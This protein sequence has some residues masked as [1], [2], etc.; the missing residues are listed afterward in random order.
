M[1]LMTDTCAL[2]TGT[3]ASPRSETIAASL[4]RPSDLHKI[5]LVFP[6]RPSAP[7]HQRNHWT[8][9][10]RSNTLSTGT[11]GID[12]REYGDSEN[13]TNLPPKP[14]RRGH[15][16]QPSPACKAYC[17]SLNLNDITRTYLWRKSSDRIP[18][19]TCPPF[20]DT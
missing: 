3:I 19:V 20:A 15:S 16:Y 7:K 6:I 11:S 4:L 13:Y 5:K 12:D 8:V 17:L 14:T 9:C 1:T 18:A 2:T 10:C